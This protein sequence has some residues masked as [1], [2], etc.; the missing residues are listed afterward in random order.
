MLL[1]MGHLISEGYA[2]V[3]GS[4]DDIESLRSTI[5]AYFNENASIPDSGTPYASYSGAVR[6]LS[7]GVGDLSLIHI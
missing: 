1:P 6:C 2:P 5:Y 7:E 4:T 3:V